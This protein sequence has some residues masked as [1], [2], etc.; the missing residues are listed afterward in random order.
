MQLV[1]NFAGDVHASFGVSDF[2]PL[3]V[4]KHVGKVPQRDVGLAFGIEEP[5]VDPPR[6]Q[7]PLHARHNTQAGPRFVCQG[8]ASAA[9]LSCASCMGDRRE[10]KSV[11][12]DHSLKASQF[13]VKSALACSNVA[14]LP[15]VATL[16]RGST[17]TTIDQNHASS[18][19]AGACS[20]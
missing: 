14:A 10:S 7:H 17:M 19:L 11:S 9:T 12:G 16:T 1:Q 20:S 13:A 8:R 5:V 6:D 18:G 15:L 3:T 2:D 4:H